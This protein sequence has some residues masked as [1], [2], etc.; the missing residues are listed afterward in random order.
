MK[1]L[2]LAALLCLNLSAETIINGDIQ[3]AQVETQ[4]AGNLKID[5]KKT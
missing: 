5:G 1:K 4:Y 3:I 2:F